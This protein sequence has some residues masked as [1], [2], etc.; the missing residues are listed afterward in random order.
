MTGRKVSIGL[1]LRE[2]REGMA[3]LVEEFV[4][5]FQAVSGYPPGDHRVC[6][7]SAREGAAAVAALGRGGVA[8][9]LLEFYAQLGSVCLPDLEAGI[10]IDDAASL[11]SQVEAGNYPRLLAGAVDDGVSV[12]A[13]DGGGGMYAVSH[14]SGCVYHLTLGALTGS[15]YDVEEAGYTVTATSLTA[16]LH[17]LRDRL[18]HA[19]GEQRVSLNQQGGEE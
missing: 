2:W 9:S 19:V 14:S 7:V 16:F 1:D 12:F 17:R 3:L 13:T 15:T 11:I 8:G 4:A 18:A 5:G 10:W 6:L